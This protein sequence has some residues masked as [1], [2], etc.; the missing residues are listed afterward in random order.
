MCLVGCSVASLA[1]AQQRPGALCL[2]VAVVRHVPRCTAAWPPAGWSAP[3]SSLC[4]PHFGSYPGEHVSGGWTLLWPAFSCHSLCSVPVTV[5]APESAAEARD[6]PALGDL[7]VSRAGRS[8][9]RYSGGVR[10]KRGVCSPARMLFL[11]SFPVAGSF[12]S[13][14]S[15]LRGSCFRSACANDPSDPEWLAAPRSSLARAQRGQCVARRGCVQLG[16]APGVAWVLRGSHGSLVLLDPHAS[17]CLLFSRQR[18]KCEST[19][20][21]VSAFARVIHAEVRLGQNGSR[22]QNPQ[23]GGVSERVRLY[24]APPGSREWGPPAPLPSDPKQLPVTSSS[25]FSAEL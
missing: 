21:R 6:A 17:P 9:R 20:G 15:Q 4:L 19:C 25:L 7:A 24:G 14:I 12:L 16:W 8:S 13:F 23:E 11:L 3:S 2:L 10:W 5:P 1:S 22:G 18:R